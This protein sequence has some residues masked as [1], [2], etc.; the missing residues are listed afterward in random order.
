VS[1]VVF[2]FKTE[3]PAVV[4]GNVEVAAGHPRTNQ[5]LCVGFEENETYSALSEALPGVAERTG[6]TVN[7][8]TQTRIG[9]RRPGKG[10]G[11]NTALRYFVSDTDERR[12]HFYDSDI[13][14]FAADWIT[15]A[16]EAADFDYGVVRHF[17]PR[18]ST[19]AMITWLVTRTGFAIIW[20]RT[21]LPWIEQPLGGELLFTREVATHL[22]AD[23]RVQAQSDWG[24]DTLYT[25]SVVQ[26]GFPLME[27]YVR[28]GKAHRLYGRLTDLRTMLVECFAAL[29]DLR[30]ER[31][32]DH[33]LHRVEYPDVVPHSIA[34]KLGYNIE[35][36]MRLLSERWTPRQDEL[37]EFFPTAVRDGMLANRRHATFEFMDETHW[38]DSFLVLL[39]RF[40]RGDRDW[41]ELLFRLWAT[42]VLNYTTTAAVRGY[43]YAL[44]HLHGMV[45]R[46]M[47]RSALGI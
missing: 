43:S 4:V 33:S 23:P 47:R 18:A 40:E 36:T 26:A 34:E 38:Y 22:L 1:L 46:Y 30:D 13:T 16:E 17:F 42:R 29:Q 11:M 9:S 28:A 8:V 5:V 37:L 39:E 31:V 19:D 27:V 32:P 15:T 25:F 12:V 21:E 14:S 24:V 44:R 6:K 7:L 20:P 2:P 35:P 41:E 45:H 10:D 3:D